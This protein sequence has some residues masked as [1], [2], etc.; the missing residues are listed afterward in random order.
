M[1][2]K[3]TNLYC[4]NRADAAIY[5]S[6][7]IDHRR[8]DSDSAR[9][10]DDTDIVVSIINIVIHVYLMSYFGGREYSNTRRPNSRRQ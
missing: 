8:D 6:R 1:A 10:V 3:L 5:L 9:Q 2:A 4:F 7:G